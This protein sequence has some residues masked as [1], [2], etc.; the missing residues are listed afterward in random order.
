MLLTHGLLKSEVFG[1]QARSEVRYQGDVMTDSGR[2]G[3]RLVSR[4]NIIS[5]ATNLMMRWTQQ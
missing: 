3:R 2:I 5:D 1:V 4:D